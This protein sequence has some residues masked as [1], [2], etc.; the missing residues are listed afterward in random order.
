MTYPHA[1]PEANH[2]FLHNIPPIDENP[3]RGGFQKPVN[4]LERCSLS[5]TALPDQSD[6][7]PDSMVKFSS[8]KMGRFSNDFV[9][10]S[11]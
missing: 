2:V 10:C 9:T 8:F 6:Q 5:A 3:P 4:H 11:N 7:P 1:P